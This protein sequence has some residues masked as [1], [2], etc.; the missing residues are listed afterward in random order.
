MAKRSEL[1][2]LA[3]VVVLEVEE[4]LVAAEVEVDLEVMIEVVGIVTVVDMVTD[5]KTA[6]MAED[7]EAVVEHL[8]AEGEVKK[9]V[10][11]HLNSTSMV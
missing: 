4:D 5:T 3:L 1:I 7:L 11:L 2:T 6:V 8:E 10:Q 9:S